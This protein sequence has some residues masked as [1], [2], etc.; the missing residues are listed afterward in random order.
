MKIL[1][2]N[3]GPAPIQA[4]DR[5]PVDDFWYQQIVAPVAAGVAVDPDSALA[6]PV[7]YACHRVLSDTIAG[8]PFGMFERG[9]NG[10]RRKMDNHPVSRLLNEPN[11]DMTSF[12]FFA[13]MIWDLA[14]RGNSYWE[15]V[16]SEFGTPAKLLHLNARYV[17][18]ER[19]SD[20]S[21]RYRYSEPGRPERYLSSDIVW[22][23]KMPP[24]VDAMVGQSPVYAGRETIGAALALQDYAA[25]FFSNNATPPFVIKHPSNFKDADS[26]RNFLNAIKRWWGGSNRH[27]PA[28]LEFGMDVAKLGVN[29]EEAQFLETRQELDKTIARIWRMPPHKVGIM[30]DATFSNI[31]QQALEFVTDTLLPWLRL[32][33][34]S[35]AKNLIINPQRYFFEFNVAGLLRGDLKSRYEAYAIARNWGW[36]SVNEI[37]RRENENPIG[38]EGDIYLQ[39]LNMQEAGAPDRTAPTSPAQPPRRANG[40]DHPLVN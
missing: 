28:V 12:E 8:L 11:D 17:T 2:I 40:A 22:H 30:A 13:Q 27:S 38:A 10:D 5:S 25:R 1:G 20:G 7:V 33:E 31:E 26:K 21:I 4:Q 37:R 15:A 16:P 9:E 6:Q 18:V 14:G 29:N 24:L 19:V 23:L 35:I 32:V 3:F 39:P 34:R 36:L